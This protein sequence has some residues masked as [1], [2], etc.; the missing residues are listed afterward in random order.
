MA[1]RTIVVVGGGFAGLWSAAAA[2]RARVE[3]GLTDQVAITLVAPD[4]FPLYPG[5]MM[6]RDRLTPLAVP[7][8]EVLDPIDVDR[9]EGQRDQDRRRRSSSDGARPGQTEP[10]ALEYDR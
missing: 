10:I 6:L 7:L 5:A 4:P 2:A 1:K 9:I 3:L 8:D